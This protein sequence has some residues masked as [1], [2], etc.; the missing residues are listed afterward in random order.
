MERRIGREKKRDSSVRMTRPDT[1]GLQ[2]RRGHEPAK[3]IGGFF[4]AR[5][6]KKTVPL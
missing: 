1:A 6:G 4:E 5:K 2:D 3:E